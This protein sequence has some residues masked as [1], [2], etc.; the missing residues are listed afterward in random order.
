[1]AAS[2]LSAGNYHQRSSNVAGID[3]TTF[4]SRR[5]IVTT[6]LLSSSSS[7]CCRC[8]WLPELLPPTPTPPLPLS[9]FG[10]ISFVVLSLNRGA[11]AV[12]KAWVVAEVGSKPP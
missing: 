9:W 2:P 10:F 11:G 4:G 8:M 7:R 5:N 3:R 6:E 1:M 12:V